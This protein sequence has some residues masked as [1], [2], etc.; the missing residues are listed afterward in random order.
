[1]EK[2]TPLYDVHVAL[3]GKMVPFAGY[4]LPVQYGTGIVTEHM[5]VREKAGLFDV[6]HMGEVTLTGSDALA[7]LNEIL[8]NDFTN[9][10]DGQARYT[11]L[12][13]EDGGCID[14]LIVY[15][16]AEN[17]YLLVV[18]AANRDKD[19]A[20]LKAHAFGD[21]WFTDVSDEWG[22]LAL[23]GPLAL[24]IL[25]LLTEVTNIPAKFYHAV[26]D[27]EVA[28]V[29]C[30]VSRT[31]Y[32]GEEGVEL[33][34][35]A[36]QVAGLWQA[37][38]DVGAPHGL[39]P[40]GLG[41]RDTLRMEAAMPLYGHEMNETVTPLETGLGFAVK[42][43]KPNFIGKVALE[44]APRR[45]R[46]GLRVTGRGIIREGQPVMAGERQI[47]TTTSGTHCPYLG[48]PV[49]MALVDK[50]S[51]AIGD[52]VEAVVRGRKVAAE[53]CALPFYKRAK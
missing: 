29:P 26:F 30:I 50:G 44:A 46:I 27:A 2:H 36:D 39:I 33:Y 21:A 7:N 11:V 1:M 20:W 22:Q 41:A 48:Q 45:E 6:S 53:V 23:Q 42:M 8:T 35:A 24:K 4:M 9:M 51:V 15:K 52:Q 19:V 5:A 16:K 17:D 43:A 14:D 18:N 13:Q 47:G 37:I 38:M 10:V 32:T 25:E 3:G 28:G 49:A 40:C 31:G 34:V 12:C